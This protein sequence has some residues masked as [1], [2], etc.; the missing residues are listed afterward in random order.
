MSH[1]IVQR[2]FTYSAQV[3]PA[4]RNA[5]SYP[6]TRR[7]R[8]IVWNIYYRHFRPGDTLLDLNCGTGDDA[9]ELASAGIRVLATDGSAEMIEEVQRKLYGTAIRTLVTP[10]QLS[11]QRLYALNG[12]QFD[13]AYSNLGGLNMT[14]RLDQIAGDLARL[15]R[16]GGYVVLNVMSKTCLWETASYLLRGKWKKAF[17]RRSPD[18]VLANLNGERV[19]MR[20]YSPD[21][22]ERAFQRQFNVVS[23]KGLNILTPP[24][25][26]LPARKMLGRGIRILESLD[27]SLPSNSSL[28]GLGDFYVI[29]FQRRGQ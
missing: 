28:H 20:Y 26:A 13:G 21:E 15:V 27:D 8:R 17:Q 19:W 10:M 25:S 9:M 14:N 3:D 2:G 11:F 22:I 6:A 1:T 5:E 7:I 24:P 4:N 16:P 18:G 12:R 23:V 29:V